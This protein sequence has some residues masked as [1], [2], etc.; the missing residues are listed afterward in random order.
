MQRIPE[1]ALY[2]AKEILDPTM[3]LLLSLFGLAAAAIAWRAGRRR[4]V[5][6]ALT[7][8]VLALLVLDWV[9]WNTP[10]DFRFQLLTSARR[11]VVSLVLSLALLGPMLLESVLAARPENPRGR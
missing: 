2:L 10:I 7:P 5:A 11:V 4:E 3:W 1:A 8:L 6:F 9:Y